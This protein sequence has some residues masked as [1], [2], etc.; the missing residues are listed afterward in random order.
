MKKVFAVALVA[1]MGVSAHAGVVKLEKAP[2]AGD[3]GPFIATSTSGYNGAT[4]AMGQ[5]LTFCLEKNVPFV[6]GGLHNTTISTKTGG[7][8]QE[9]P[10]SAKTAYLYFNFRMGT[11]AGYTAGNLADG[12]ALQE[13]IWALEN[14][15]N[16]PAPGVNKFYD[17]AL[18]SNWT[19]IG[20]VRV[21]QIGNPDG[22]CGQ[23][24]LT[25]VP[26]PTA[27]WMGL[28]TLGVAAGLRRRVK[29]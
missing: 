11:L 8:G 20:M 6:P 27:A 29:A 25:L 15:M 3:H 16:A 4:N 21:L 14:E 28:A 24:Q 22:S 26:L 7:N 1:I 5:F 18:K 9:D 19:D 12:L 23:D 10:I 2:F 17:L 13:A